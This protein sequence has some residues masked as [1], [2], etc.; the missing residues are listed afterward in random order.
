M[1]ER[2]VTICSVSFQSTSHLEL[3]WIVTS[4]LNPTQQL[5]WVV[6]ANT[7]RDADDLLALESGHFV[8]ARGAEF[9]PSK[10]RP[11]SYHHGVGLNR[12]MELVNTR[13]VAILDPDFY[14]VRTN[15]LSEVLEYMQ[16]TGVALFGVPWHPRW[17][18][19]YRYFPCVHCL[20]IDLAQVPAEALDF[21]PG[22]GGL[23]SEKPAWKAT[24]F[25]ALKRW[26]PSP[27]LDVLHN[28]RGR[29][30]IGA[31][32]DTGYGLYHQYG[33]STVIRSECVVPVYRPEVDYPV[34]SPLA[35]SR[36]ADQLLPDRLSYRPKR[37]NYSTRSGFRELGYVDVATHGWEEFVWQGQPFGFHMRRQRGVNRDPES[38]MATLVQV[39]MNLTHV[40]L[41]TPSAADP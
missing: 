24:V 21:R 35:L 22:G 1:H 38:E 3:N 39:I 14:I 41:R 28:L 30:A 31:S 40:E 36:L 29:K 20:F 25:A 12:A 6:T 18:T 16:A 15:W 7:P 4:R 23:A 19:K 32:Q 37:P 34:T 10:P 13:F 11:A 33:R 8:V 2:G 5:T 27:I 26:L 9:D 17:H